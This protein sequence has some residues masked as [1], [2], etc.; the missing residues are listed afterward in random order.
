MIATIV[1]QAALVGTVILVAIIVW[2]R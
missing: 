2:R 1:L